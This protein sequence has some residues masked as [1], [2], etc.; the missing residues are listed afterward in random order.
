MAENRDL[1]VFAYGSLM[2]R[3]GFAFT[4]VAHA[5]LI[6]WRRS[7]CIYSRYHRGSERR[8]GLVLGL[9]RGG[10]CEGLAFRV[11]AADV[12][13]V[14]RY[15]RE[16]EQI[17]SVYREALVP[18]TLTTPGRPEVMALAFLVERAHPSYAGTL[19][20]AEQAHLIR[21]AKGRSGGN[22]DYLASTLAHLTELGIRERS[23]ER[24]MSLVGVHV[25]HGGDADQK[26]VRAAAL[27][28]GMRSRPVRL[29]R[30]LRPEDARRFAYRSV[31]GA[32]S[33]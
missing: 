31:L 1:W 16:R 32:R 25:A 33:E 12:A 11:P 24:L 14:L 15:L 3:P 13:A 21:G 17:I 9:D 5:K 29:R 2:W 10:T 18:V 28:N 19:A 26:R 4:Q 7:F 6:G 8:P 20:L 27:L 22:I 30:R 23:L